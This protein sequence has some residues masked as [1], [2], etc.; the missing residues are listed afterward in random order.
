MLTSNTDVFVLNILYILSYAYFSSPVASFPFQGPVGA[1]GIAGVM[2][3]PGEKV[4]SL[5]LYH[6]AVS[7]H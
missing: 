2:G 4:K 1:I 3:V 7:Q 5:F 6:Y